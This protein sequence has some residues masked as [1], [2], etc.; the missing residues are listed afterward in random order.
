MYSFSFL[1]RNINKWSPVTHPYHEVGVF[2][3]LVRAFQIV[4]LRTRILE[5]IPKAA[6]GALIH[7]QHFQAGPT[8]PSPLQSHL[9]TLMVAIKETRD[10]PG[11]GDLILSP[12]SHQTNSAISCPIGLTHYFPV[13]CFRMFSVTCLLSFPNKA[14]GN[15][16]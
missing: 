8:H 10:T 14:G 1:P 12:P 4:N 15:E 2:S 3:H 11:F 9:L 13:F 6:T 16:Y 5:H 7:C